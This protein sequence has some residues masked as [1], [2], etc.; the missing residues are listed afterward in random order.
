MTPKYIDREALVAVLNWRMTEPSYYLVPPRP[1]P[2]MPHVLEYAPECKDFQLHQVEVSMTQTRVCTTSM[3]FPRTHG[4]RPI[5][6]VCEFSS[7]TIQLAAA[8]RPS[9]PC[10][11]AHPSSSSWKEKES[12]RTQSAPPSRRRN[13]SMDLRRCGR[14]PSN[15]VTSSTFHRTAPYA[16]RS[17]STD[18][19]GCSVSVP[20]GNTHLPYKIGVIQ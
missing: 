5:C 16:S 4:N 6:K 20:A 2:Q 18:T 19:S 7:T 13:R 8:S 11:I 10:S 9:C 1:L 14:D 15:A 17:S 12:A 3:T